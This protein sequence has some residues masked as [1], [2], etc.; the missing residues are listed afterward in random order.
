MHGAFWYLALSAEIVAWLHISVLELLATGF[1]TII[2]RTTLP[3]RSRLVLGADAS[4]TVTTLTRE[5]ESSEMLV[6]THHELLGTPEFTAA[7]PAADLGQLRGDANI[8]ADAVSRAEWEVFFRLCRN[9][10][11]RP[12][13]L[14]GDANLAADAVSRAEWEVFFRLCRN[15][16][17]RPIQLQVPDSC[18]QILQRT[19]AHAQRR[20]IMVRPNHYQSAP[21]TIPPPLLPYVDSQVPVRNVAPRISSTHYG[22]AC[23]AALRAL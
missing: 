12:I 7:A 19:L 10:R 15:L 23:W 22:V 9:L 6:L 8:A 11:I 2:F 18:L 1:S 14:R 21:T 20:G 5:T 16:R 4:A 13:Q 17:I 3:P